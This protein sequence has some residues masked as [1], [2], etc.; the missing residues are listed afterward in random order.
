MI[1]VPMT[2]LNREAV[3]ELQAFSTARP[4][5]AG[6]SLHSVWCAGCTNG[7]WI[8]RSSGSRKNSPRTPRSW[9][10]IR[11]RCK[12]GYNYGETVEVMP[13]HYRVPKAKLPPGTYRKITGNEAL[14]MGLVAADSTRSE[15]TRL[16]Q[17][18]DHSGQ[19]HPERAGRHEKIRRQD[20]QAEDEIAADRHGHRRRLRRRHRRR[21]A[22]AVP[23]SA[24]SRGDRPGR[25]D[26]VAA[27]RHQRAARRPEHRPADQDRT[28]RPVASDVRPQRRMPARRLSRRSARPIASTWRSKPSASPSD[29]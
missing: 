20:L 21:P 24:S 27:D 25:D 15:A 17:L 5:A 29:S 14:A 4:I 11:G 16:L 10:P 28:G 26:R 13:V 8:P 3:A 7:R 2:K 6:T 9:K 22:P 19:R 12:A 1:R 18:P 23:A